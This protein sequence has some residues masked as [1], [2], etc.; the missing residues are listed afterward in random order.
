MHGMVVTSIDARVDPAC[1]EAL[2]AGYRALKE[3]GQPDA[4]LRSELLRGQDQHWRI[5]TTWRDLESL[6][7][8]RSSGVRPAALELFESVGAEHSHT[9][10]TVQ[11][12]YEA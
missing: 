7:A 6:R 9:F 3:G 10:F 2:L 4:L 5:Q 8:I 11:D 12:S 1:E